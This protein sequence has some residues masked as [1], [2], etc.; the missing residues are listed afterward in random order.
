MA[1]DKIIVVDDEMIIRKSLE[2]QLR[3][4]RYAVAS[5]STIA[6]CE[7]YMAKDQ[8]DLI[9]LDV[10]LPDGDGTELLERIAEDPDK[11][12]VVMMTGYGSIESAVHCMRLGA[13][14]YVI[15]PFSQEQI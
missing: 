10:R 4:K 9:L 2:Q 6:E 1:F 3:N 11:P 5:A 12:M 13:F 15:K 8:F 7:A 14:D